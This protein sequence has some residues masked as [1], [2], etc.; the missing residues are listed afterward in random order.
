[1]GMPVISAMLPQSARHT[2]STSF[3]WGTV[4]SMRPRGFGNVRFE[5]SI[6]C[7]KVP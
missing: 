6:D 5:F 7:A 1:M 2:S 4:A 3:E